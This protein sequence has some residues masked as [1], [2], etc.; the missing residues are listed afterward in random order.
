MFDPS[1]WLAGRRE[2]SREPGRH[3]SWPPEVAAGWGDPREGMAGNTMASPLEVDQQQQQQQLG[4]GFGPG[5]QPA[6]QGIR[7]NCENS[8]HDIQG[9]SGQSGASPAVELPH[10][11]SASKHFSSHFGSISI[12]P[13]LH[14]IQPFIAKKV[15]LVRLRQGLG[16]ATPRIRTKRLDFTLVGAVHDILGLRTFPLPVRD[17]NELKIRSDLFRSYLFGL[18][19][20]LVN[21]PKGPEE[22]CAQNWV[23]NGHQQL[24]P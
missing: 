7:T 19:A 4:I 3:R 6:L 22:C 1:E 10:P 21:P 11:I 9:E 20:P 5:M 12:E 14:Q 16:D 17:Q 24:T 8:Q 23:Q 2:G 18:F 15:A 13:L